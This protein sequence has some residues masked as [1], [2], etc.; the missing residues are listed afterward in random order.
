MG[1]SLGGVWEATTWRPLR[2]EESRGPPALALGRPAAHTL[3]PLLQPPAAAWTA[4]PCFQV[5]V[6][7]GDPV[8]LIGALRG[9]VYLPSALKPRDTR[10]TA[11]L[12]NAQRGAASKGQAGRW[13]GKAQ[14]QSLLTGATPHLP[15]WREPPHRPPTTVTG[16]APPDPAPERPRRGGRCCPRSSLVPTYSPCFR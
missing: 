14:D 8:S 12:P 4:V 6:P 10:G 15:G 16:Q 1:G 7:V 2:P 9:A 3:P 5:R 13:A 11:T